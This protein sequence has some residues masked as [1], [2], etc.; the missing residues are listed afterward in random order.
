MASASALTENRSAVRVEA[1]DALRLS[2]IRAGLA[3]ASLAVLS[4]DPSAPARFGALA[5]GSLAAYF[6]YALG[7]SYLSARA[8]RATPQRWLH[9]VDV[10]FFSYLMC[11]T[12]GTQSVFF[13]YFFFP[14]MV[15]AFS[16]GFREGVLVTSISTLSY[17]SLG[18]LATPWSGDFDLTRLMIRPVYLLTLGYMLAYWGGHEVRLKRQ[19]LLLQAINHT[20]NPRLGVQITIADSLQRLREFYGADRCFLVTTNNAGKPRY[21]MYASCAGDDAARFDA[22]ISDA[23]G[24]LLL[25]QPDTHAF[26]CHPTQSAWTRA[27]A[28]VIW[29]IRN[30]LRRSPGPQAWSVEVANVIGAGSFTSVPYLQRNGTRGRLFVGAEG[31]LSLQ[32]VAFILHFSGALAVVVENT[33]LIEELVSSA[34]AR[35]R[36]RLSLDIHDTTIQPYIALRM[37]LEAVYRDADEDSGVRESLRELIA[38]ADLTV[39]DLRNYAAGLRGTGQ[40]ASNVLASAVQEQAARYERFFGVQVKVDIDTG[41]HLGSVESDI[42][43][44][45][46]EGLSNVRKHTSSNKAYIRVARDA[47]ALRI[48]I[49]NEAKGRRACA[50]TPRSIEQRARTLGGTV[51]VG[52]EDGYTLVNVSVPI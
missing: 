30:R 28:C 31:R 12:E 17:L 36:S 9:W 38:M 51:D 29:D 47:I 3:L 14:I 5:H 10:A 26:T 49:G 37:G 48:Q 11:L 50:F 35:E 39:S 33:Q 1:F 15:A 34:S 13:L 19:L 7:I 52:L 20:R 25:A 23:V 8:R 16:Y 44:I 6:V 41:S 18:M 22:D 40:R 32:D 46:V 27:P 21:A 2:Y 4:I 42:F 43:Q 45:I 24:E